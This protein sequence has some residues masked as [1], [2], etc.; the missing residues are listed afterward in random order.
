MIKDA[1]FSLQM[2]KASQ[3]TE[4][5]EAK[6][7]GAISGQLEEKVWP[8]SKA[9]LVTFAEGREG[10]ACRMGGAYGPPT[11]RHKQLFSLYSIQYSI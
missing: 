10:V 9:V 11:H 7:M 5:C 4:L 8:I 6:N 3:H 2:Y 1:L